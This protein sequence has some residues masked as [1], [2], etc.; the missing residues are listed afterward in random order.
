L[1]V[2][3]EPIA[4]VVMGLWTIYIK[5]DHCRKLD[6]LVYFSDEGILVYINTNNNEI[7][8]SRKEQIK[9]YLCATQFWCPKRQG[10]DQML[11]FLDG[12]IRI[13]SYLTRTRAL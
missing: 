2:I 6:G 9:Q 8:Q 7:C 3:T 4:V 11:W 13:A 12:I 10:I 5:F 1:F